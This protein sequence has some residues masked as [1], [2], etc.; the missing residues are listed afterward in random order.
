MAQS[1][2]PLQKESKVLLIK[3]EGNF[4]GV[5]RCHHT[6][7]E[8][9]LAHS[10]SGQ[11][12]L[13]QGVSQKLQTR[14]SAIAHAHGY[15]PPPGTRAHA[16]LV[17]QQSLHALFDSF[18][19]DMHHLPIPESPTTQL[20]ANRV[21]QLENTVYQLHDMDEDAEVDQALSV[22][23]GDTSDKEAVLS[24]PRRNPHASSAP[25]PRANAPPPLPTSQNRSILS[26][27]LPEAAVRA[28]GA[29]T[30][31]SSGH[32][33]G[34]VQG[35]PTHRNALWNADMIAPFA[36]EKLHFAEHPG[37]SL[38][39]MSHFG[40]VS[41]PTNRAQRGTEIPDGSGTS[42][43]TH[44][45][46]GALNAHQLPSQRTPVAAVKGSD[47]LQVEADADM[48][49]ESLTPLPIPA[50]AGVLPDGMTVAE[51][52]RS[53]HGKLH[54]LIFL[55]SQ[56]NSAVLQKSDMS[57][58]YLWADESLG[59]TIAQL[60][61]GM[62][63]C[64]PQGPAAKLFGYLGCPEPTLFDDMAANL[65][66]IKGLV[67]AHPAP[68]PA[69]TPPAAS[70]PHTAAPLAGKHAAQAA[71]PNSYAGRAA[72]QAANASAAPRVSAPP[73]PAAPPT[74]PR[75]R[76]HSAR[77][78][79]SVHA[80][81]ELTAHIRSDAKRLHDDVNK[82]QRLDSRFQNEATFA[83]ARGGF[84]LHFDNARRG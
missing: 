74:N 44:A 61:K 51:A 71:N 68:A 27:A 16:Y 72:R 70:A 28:T 11:Q 10:R 5:Y 23:S 62:Q 30:A 52:I 38:E 53:M 59:L 26:P 56:I 4:C 82:T 50:D 20:R 66:R 69:P 1:D 49:T 36:P 84:A 8:L 83:F 35:T 32:G 24:T 21:Q 41:M 54:D 64:A 9:W 63:M 60:A 75:A 58:V 31:R 78:I 40:R 13:V 15:I 33:S 7:E 43:A 2:S 17:H 80:T 55:T 39:D 46:Q 67:G 29:A 65:E 6:K 42:S 3:T 47:D 22:M 79:L 18:D 48:E 12:H 25:H 76:H 19:S 45:Q 73:K 37:E 77:L 14:S 81:P 34:T 57:D